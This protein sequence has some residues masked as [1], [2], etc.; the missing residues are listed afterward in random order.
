M[1]LCEYPRTM[2]AGSAV[3][4][5]VEGQLPDG[6]RVLFRPLRR[7][8]R[9]GLR[10]GVERMSPESRY[11]RF[12]TPLEHLSEAQLDYLVQIDYVNHFAWL[13]LLP[14]EIGAPGIGVSR[15]VRAA[16]DPTS[17]DAAV[18]VIDDYQRMGMGSSLLLL[19]AGSAIA[20]GVRTFRVEVLGQNEGML[21]LVKSYGAEVVEEAGGVQ[22]LLVP[23]PATLE[24]L[25]H[26]PAPRILA[27]TA[28]GRLAGQAGA[29]GLGT[30]LHFDAGGD[31][32]G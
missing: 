4:N 22:Y 23:L 24:E 11:R 2:D 32:H 30:R 13:A 26:T 1:A 8:D 20:R 14:D 9:E 25:A 18:A 16:G 28:A 31:G 12:F 19:L 10:R 21:R 15:W 5:Q 17:A 27:A 3:E 6:R 29:R 7:E